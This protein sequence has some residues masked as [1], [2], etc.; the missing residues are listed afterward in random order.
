MNET[1]LEGQ[2]D[3]AYEN[4]ELK[5]RNEKAE[6]VLKELKGLFGHVAVKVAEAGMDMGAENGVPEFN[7]D[8]K[9][10]NDTLSIGSSPS[11]ITYPD[12]SVSISQTT[13]TMTL[14]PPSIFS[15]A[16]PNTLDT[17]SNTWAVPPRRRINRM[18]KGIP[19]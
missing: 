10:P 16:M 15:Q 4:S 9:I 2:Y 8:L 7:K 6:G 17:K 12:G 11:V 13:T 14:G 1:E 3:Y 19:Y 5:T 18:R